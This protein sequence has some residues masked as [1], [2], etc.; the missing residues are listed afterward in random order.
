MTKTEL[1]KKV[2]DLLKVV[3][4]SE[5]TEMPRYWS[6]YC[7]YQAKWVNGKRKPLFPKS[8]T[9]ADL[10]EDRSRVVLHVRFAHWME[11]QDDSWG[12]MVPLP[13]GDNEVAITDRMIEMGYAW[14]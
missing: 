12:D 11:G 13:G 2:A 14:E 3:E 9:P 10:W 8:L 1:D 6:V 4:S 5:G 7:R